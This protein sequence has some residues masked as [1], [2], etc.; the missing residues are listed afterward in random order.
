M[1]S[2]PYYVGIALH[3]LWHSPSLYITHAAEDQYWVQEHI[4]SIQH[5]SIHSPKTLTVQLEYDPNNSN[6]RKQ[7]I[8]YTPHTI[9]YGHIADTIDMHDT[10]VMWPLFYHDIDPTLFEQL[11]HKRIVLGNFGMFTYPVDGMMAKQHPERARALLQYVDYLFLDEDEMLF[12][13]EKSSLDEAI[14]SLENIVSHIVVTRWSQGSMLHIRG[15][16]YHIPAFTPENIVDTTGAGDTYLA[17]FLAKE[18]EIDDYDVVGRFAAMATT[19]KI[20]KT[21]PLITPKDEIEKRMI[22]YGL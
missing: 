11:S 3:T 5:T 1:G 10:I 9:H 18:K 15:K 14:H 8:S 21:W 16:R 22:S 12:L 13:T 2:I 20:E 6:K 17:A 4:G 19:C 7:K